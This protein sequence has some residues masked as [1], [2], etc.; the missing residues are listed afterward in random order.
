MEDS[1][2]ICTKLLHHGKLIAAA[3]GNMVVTVTSGDG[4]FGLT[5]RENKPKIK[6]N[7]LMPRRGAAARKRRT[8][9]RLL[10]RMTSANENDENEEI[11]DLENNENEEIP[12][13]EN[14]E[15]DKLRRGESHLLFK[16]S[17]PTPEQ[18]QTT[19]LVRDTVGP[20]HGDPNSSKAEEM[21]HLHD[22]ARLYNRNVVPNRSDAGDDQ[23]RIESP[24]GTQKTFCIKQTS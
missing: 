17:T 12:D 1:E 2:E 3:H 24:F 7:V 6:K 18:N 19:N 20:T 5:L 11:P 13:L 21:Q 22:T 9:K 16:S 4:I 15:N 14:D 8:E 10:A 23:V